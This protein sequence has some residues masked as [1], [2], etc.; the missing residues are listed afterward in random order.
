LTRRFVL[1]SEVLGYCLSGAV[2]LGVIVTVFV[3]VD[4]I[5]HAKAELRPKCHDVTCPEDFLLVEYLVANG[6]H[7]V[8]E[9][10]IAHVLLGNTAQQR[11]LARR[12]LRESAS[13]LEHEAGTNSRAAAEELKRALAILPPIEDI[14][15]IM[16]SHSGVLRHNHVPWEDGVLSGGTP[17]ALVC[18]LQTL[19]MKG[20]LGD[21]RTN[22]RLAVGQRARVFMDDLREVVMGDVV[23]FHRGTNEIDFRL[24]FTGV[25]PK[26]QDYFRDKFVS[27]PVG[28]SLVL[29]AEIIVG[30]QSVFTEMFS[31]GK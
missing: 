24:E 9:Q 19:E 18:D 20:K 5:V 26:I 8:A 13:L 11:S 15:S 28:A 2:F 25:S 14:E 30:S 22:D 27:A 6:E 3:R 17:L 29:Q 10:P 1:L 16:T 12:Q 23:E 31:R 21:S 7:V 4:V